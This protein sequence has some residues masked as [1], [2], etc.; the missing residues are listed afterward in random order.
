MKAA[1]PNEGLAPSAASGTHFVDVKKCSFATRRA[2]QAS[3]VVLIAIN[4]RIARTAK[5][6][7]SATHRKRW[8]PAAP[9]SRAVRLVPGVAGA[10]VASVTSTA[11][12]P[13]DGRSADRHLVELGDRLGGQVGRQLGVVGLRLFGLPVGQHEVHKALDRRA[14]L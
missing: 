9:R 14:Q 1:A 13:R 6:A 11:S 10:S 12:L 3:L 7:M 4:A 2:G 8:S 5:P